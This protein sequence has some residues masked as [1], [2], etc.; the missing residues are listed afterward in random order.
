VI[1]AQIRAQGVGDQHAVVRAQDGAAEGTEP[2]VAAGAA[3]CAEA[4]QGTVA[5]EQRGRDV[6]VAAARAGDG[7]SAAGTLA[8]AEGAGPE[9]AAGL[10]V[11][12]AG[13]PDEEGGAVDGDG[14]AGPQGK[15]VGVVVREEAVQD[16]KGGAVGRRGA[17]APGDEGAGRRVAGPAA[18][19][20]NEV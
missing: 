1:D 5:A 16:A 10:V 3:E 18:G 8:G 6:R 2:G 4:A 19:H 17:A 11:E 15:A 20:N 7:A 12:E 13:P 14:A 9:R